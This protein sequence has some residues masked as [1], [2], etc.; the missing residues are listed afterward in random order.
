MCKTSKTD[1][2]PPEGCGA[3]I[4]IA[5]H[6]LVG[7][8][9]GSSAEVAACPAG[10]E[11]RSGACWPTAGS[12]CPSGYSCDDAPGCVRGGA[13]TWPWWVSG[14]VAVI[15]AGAAIY[16]LTN[17]DEQEPTQEQLPPGG[18]GSAPVSFPF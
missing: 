8:E 2:A 5:V 7:L 14:G 6:P 12:D 11:A 10:T 13:V 18:L 9:E 3:L 16:L 15:G 1:T 4:R 17:K